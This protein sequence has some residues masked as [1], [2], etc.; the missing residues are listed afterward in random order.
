MPKSL[1]EVQ[2]TFFEATIF[3]FFVILIFLWSFRATLIPL[4]TL[5]VDDA[6]R[7]YIE[8]QGEED[9]GQTQFVISL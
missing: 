5:P 2:D 3:V 6:I 4:I 1:D 7:R 9:K 8:R